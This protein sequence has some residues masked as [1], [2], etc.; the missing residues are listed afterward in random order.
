MSVC[1]RDREYSP[2]EDA[3]VVLAARDRPPAPSRTSFKDGDNRGL[4]REAEGRREEQDVRQ[5]DQFNYWCERR[6]EGKMRTAVGRN[7]SRSEP[8]VGEII[9]QKEFSIKELLQTLLSS[10]SV[11]STDFKR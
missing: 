9:N 1:E 10:Q 5:T 3:A 4:D 8:Q 11:Q 6:S 7:S 2:P